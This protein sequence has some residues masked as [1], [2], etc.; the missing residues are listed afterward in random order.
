ML[1]T[2]HRYPEPPAEYYLQKNVQTMAMSIIAMPATT[3]T[4]C[5]YYPYRLHL[6]TDH[7]YHEFDRFSEMPTS[8]LRVYVENRQPPWCQHMIA[9]AF[10]PKR[11]DWPDMI[12]MNLAKKNIKNH[13]SA[14]FVCEILLLSVL[15]TAETAPKVTVPK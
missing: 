5:K 11:M 7:E 13:K 10:S 4:K 9:C 8:F 15:R 3:I 14:C 2:V 12:P 6:C 1:P